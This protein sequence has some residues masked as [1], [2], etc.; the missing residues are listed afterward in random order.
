[1][2]GFPTFPTGVTSVMIDNLQEK[3]FQTENVLFR[4][5][6]INVIEQ[7][8]AAEIAPLCSGEMLIFRNSGKA[9]SEKEIADLDYSLVL[10]KTDRF[11][12]RQSVFEGKHRLRLVFT[13]GGNEYDLPV[14]DVAFIIQSKAN[15]RCLS[16]VQ[17]LFLILSLGI[18]FN[19]LY[20]KLVA[21]IIPV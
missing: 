2:A 11:E 13:Y 5:K 9:L 14:M 18:K 4:K 12:I 7:F 8:L 10:I 20:Y 15:P 16:D 21:G 17:G 1:M 19:S 3:G 6:P